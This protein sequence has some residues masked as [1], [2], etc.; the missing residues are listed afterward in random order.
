MTREIADSRR[1]AVKGKFLFGLALFLLF[2]SLAV[3]QQGIYIKNMKPYRPYISNSIIPEG[4]RADILRAVSLGYDDMTS[5][6]LW[7]RTIQDFGGRFR[8]PFALESLSNAFW[9][10]S[11]LTPQFTE[12][13]EFGALVMGDEGGSDALWLPRVGGDPAF[14]PMLGSVEEARE[15]ARLMREDAMRFY[16]V[17]IVRDPDHFRH[18]YNAVYTSMHGFRDPERGIPYAEV[19]TIRPD[20]PGW[21]GGTIPYLRGRSGEYRVAMSLWFSQLR[22]EISEQEP[23]LYSI[24]LRK[25]AEDGSTRWDAQVLT[26]VMRIWSELN[27]GDFPIDLG[28]L[29]TDGMLEVWPEDLERVLTW[30]RDSH[31]G[32]NPADARAAIAAFAAA[33]P[34]DPPEPLGLFDFPRFLADTD[35]LIETATPFAPI[36]EEEYGLDDYLTVRNRI[37]VCPL[38]I[39][40]P[41][42]G[43]EQRLIQGSV[44]NGFHYMIDHRNRRVVDSGRLLEDTARELLTIRGMIDV[45]NEENGRYPQS[46]AEVFE[47][48]A[49]EEPIEP[50]TGQPY[51]YNP[52]T[53]IAQSG[54]FTTEA[55]IFRP[56]G[57]IPEPALLGTARALDEL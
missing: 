46:L 31:G 27:G 34:L 49:R 12:M 6:F 19:A 33:H 14:G 13:Y 1:G 26:D 15:R 44:M 16:E 47:Y 54:H 43:D 35:A 32:E 18:A 57:G 3:R 30:W 9:A 38:N 48:N 50:A 42:T 2:G 24:R 5:I 51:L 37:P 40:V 29:V 10:M 45:F 17:G 41:R 11:T 22:E 53:G 36:T 52:E 21:V 55:M 23:S 4:D 20:C 28:Q 8:D 39:W 7:L 25:I 56:F